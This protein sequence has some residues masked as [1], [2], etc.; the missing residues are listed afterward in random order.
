MAWL[1]ATSSASSRGVVWVSVRS[2]RSRG[3]PVRAAT[4]SATRS[5]GADG[6]RPSRSAMERRRSSVSSPAAWPRPLARWSRL[7]TATTSSAPGSWTGWGS[8]PRRPAPR[9]PAGEGRLQHLDAGPL[10][11]DEQ[12][13]QQHGVVGLAQL[14]VDQHAGPAQADDGAAAERLDQQ[15]GAVVPGEAGPGATTLRDLEHDPARG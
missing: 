4:V 9:A 3:I 7:P 12:A 1:R 8:A 13:G 15:P 6:G 10:D 5:A 2:T 14:L 11:R